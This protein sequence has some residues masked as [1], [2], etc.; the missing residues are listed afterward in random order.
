MTA[1]LD[2]VLSPGEQVRLRAIGAGTDEIEW[3]AALARVKGWRAANEE[4]HR[5]Q[6]EL[7]RREMFALMASLGMERR[8][9]AERAKEAV[10]I[11]VE[12]FLQNE[13]TRVVPRIKQDELHLFATRCPIYTL[14][15]DPERGGLTACG[16][17]TRRQ[18]WLDALG[19]DIEQE[20]LMNRKWGD[21]ACDSIIHD[22]APKAVTQTARLG[23]AA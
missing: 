17:F 12:L 19:A 23:G 21:P 8:A 5:R 16:C 18:G 6:R 15:L 3:P 7:G 22:R 9:R 14:L 4:Y 2:D 10:L 13:V 20:M 11:A 1:L